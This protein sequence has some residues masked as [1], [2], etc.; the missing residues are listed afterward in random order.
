MDFYLIFMGNRYDMS[1]LILIMSTT[2]DMSQISLTIPTRYITYMHEDSDFQ[3]MMT[4][5]F[6]DYSELREDQTT[7]KALDGS[8]RF[9]ALNSRFSSL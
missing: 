7:K 6:I 9:Q 8:A 2:T 5:F 1:N 4:E 3:L